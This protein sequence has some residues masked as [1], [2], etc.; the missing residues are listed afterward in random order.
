VKKQQTII[1][2][3]LA[4]A[5]LGGCAAPSPV[6]TVDVARIVANWPDYQTDQAQL[7]N[8][9]QAIAASKQSNAEKQR[10]QAAIQAK[11]AKI[12]DQLTQQIRDAAGKVAAEKQ[13]KLVVTREGVGYG[14]TDITADVEKAMNITEKAT[15]TPSP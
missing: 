4:A 2:A 12:T 8:D 14:G 13:L 15:P 1:I 6:G 7:T 10:A 3:T 5:L 11:Y 9:V